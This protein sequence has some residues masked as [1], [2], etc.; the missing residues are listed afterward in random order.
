MRDVA[1]LYVSQPDETGYAPVRAK[2]GQD[3]MMKA[4]AVTTAT[5]GANGV[6]ENILTIFERLG[7][8]NTQPRRLIA[9]RLAALSASGSDFTAQDL[10]QDLLASDP[11]MGRATVYRAVDILLGQGILDRVTFPDGTHR[12]RLCGT[13][14]HHHHLTCT[15]CQRVIEVSACLPPELLATIAHGADFELEGHSMEL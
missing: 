14:R 1:T 8:K 5:N 6:A 13:Q 11:H 15:Q 7:L 9:L 3:V 12:Y 2:A 10:W 4:S